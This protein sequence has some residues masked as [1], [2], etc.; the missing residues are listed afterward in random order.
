[1]RKLGGGEVQGHI[2]TKWMSWDLKSGHLTLP[3]RLKRTPN[4]LE[5]SAPAGEEREA[6]S[7]EAWSNKECAKEGSEVGLKGC[8][9]VKREGGRENGLSKVGR[10]E[11]AG[12]FHPGQRAGAG[13][14]REGVAGR[15]E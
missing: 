13:Q 4:H 8:G 12:S 2:D 11:G 6:H 9:E 7:K 1:M 3:Q 5:K 15:G 14:G 10:W